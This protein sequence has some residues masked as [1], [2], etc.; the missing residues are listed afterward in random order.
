MNFK[1]RL[2]LPMVLGF[3]SSCLGGKLL[4]G[5]GTRRAPAAGQIPYLDLGGAYMT[6]DI[7]TSHQA[8]Q[9]KFVHFIIL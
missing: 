2:E 5:R 3:R 1:D 4:P 7:C 6:A 9:L 8:I